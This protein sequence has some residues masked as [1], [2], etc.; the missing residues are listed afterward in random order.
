MVLLGKDWDPESWISSIV[1]GIL[2]NVF[3][4]P[5]INEMAP[6]SEFMDF[7]CKS[8]PYFLK[9]FAKSKRYYFPGCRGEAMYIGTI[10][11]SLDHCRMDWNIED[12]LWLDVDHSRFG[13]MAEIGR[14]VKVGFVSD[15]PG[16]L[17]HRRYKDSG[18]PFYDAICEKAATINVKL[19]DQM[20]TCIVK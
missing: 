7:H 3:C 2:E 8:R 9:E 15:L 16:L 19:A 18:H 12:P 1:H 20:D 11:Q 10:M 5:I 17:F 6:Y 4:H 13:K 14:I